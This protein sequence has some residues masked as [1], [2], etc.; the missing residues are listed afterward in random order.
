MQ[1]NKKIIIIIA[2]LIVFLIVTTI[3]YFLI[4]HRPKEEEI[5]YNNNQETKMSK[6]EKV[7][8]LINNYVDNNPEIFNY[9]KNN[10]LEQLTLLELKNILKIDISE[11]NELPYKCNEEETFIKFEDNYSKYFIVIACDEFLLNEEN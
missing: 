1:K 8:D 6:Q 5:I 4:F 2:I 10:N 11:F 7:T 9:A 3:L